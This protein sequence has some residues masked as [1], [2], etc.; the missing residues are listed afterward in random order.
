MMTTPA[1][2]RDARV[3]VRRVRAARDRRAVLHHAQR[4][5]LGVGEPDLHGRRAPAAVT[6]RSLRSRAAA[7]AASASPVIAPPGA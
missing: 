6:R 1:A 4:R 3:V 7:A 5:H 2:R